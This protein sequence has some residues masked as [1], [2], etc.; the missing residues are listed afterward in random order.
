MGWDYLGIEM[1]IN[2]RV[3]ASVCRAL[4]S[5]PSKDRQGC[6]G[7]GGEKR[8]LRA[9]KLAQHV[10]M[11]ATK[12]DGPSPIPRMVGRTDPCKLPSDL[13]GSVMTCVCMHSTNKLGTETETE[14]ERLKSPGAHS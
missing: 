4:S 8:E 5:N 3:L 13:C 10:K 1:Q 7:G 12:P 9:D 2:S 14:T 11:L 6:G